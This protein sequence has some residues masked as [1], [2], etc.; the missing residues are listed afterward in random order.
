MEVRSFTLQPCFCCGIRVKG[1]ELVSCS[2]TS[3]IRNWCRL[4]RR[5]SLLAKGQIPSMTRE[6]D[7]W[8][9]TL[10]PAQMSH[11]KCDVEKWQ[12]VLLLP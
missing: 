10:K 9:N 3:S 4:G 12:L 2:L 5:D 7:C 6:A 11:E 1:Y 8:Q